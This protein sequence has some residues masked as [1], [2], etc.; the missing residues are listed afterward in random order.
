MKNEKL[1]QIEDLFREYEGKLPFC[2]DNE[3]FLEKLEE[4]IEAPKMSF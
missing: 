1:E 4:I 3:K 2:F